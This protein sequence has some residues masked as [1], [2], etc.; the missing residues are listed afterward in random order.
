MELPL[1]NIIELELQNEGVVLAL[2]F[3]NDPVREICKSDLDPN[4]EFIHRSRKRLSQL[5][6]R[7]EHKKVVREHVACRVWRTHRD[8]DG[9]SDW[10]LYVYQ[11]T[12]ETFL[13]TYEEKR[14]RN[15]HALACDWLKVD[16][17]A[18]LI[19]EKAFFG[20]KVENPEDLFI[21]KAPDDKLHIAIR[22]VRESLDRLHCD[23]E[24]R[25]RHNGK[26][27]PMIITSSECPAEERI[28][29]CHYHNY[30]CEVRNH[31]WI[32]PYV[33][34]HKVIQKLQNDWIPRMERRMV[35][36]SS[37]SFKCYGLWAEDLCFWLTNEK[38]TSHGA[39]SVRDCHNALIEFTA[40]MAEK[41]VP[42]VLEQH[43]WD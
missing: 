1:L 24:V 43:K 2:K 21:E 42:V 14:K 20:E 4:S 12:Y 27:S 15:P 8:D 26:V 7:E 18:K 13:R 19:A 25:F 28:S 32:T 35:P 5:F 11:G 6:F 39:Y 34:M 16:Y 29:G 9:L 36:I 17:E 3:G 22:D 37:V 30:D 10:F 41:D 38:G 31:E 33:L 23:Y 40:F